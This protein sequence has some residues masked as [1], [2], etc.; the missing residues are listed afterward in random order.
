MHIC[1]SDIS[2]LGYTGQWD[3]NP[4]L[5]A[6]P[7]GILNL[8]D[9]KF[10]DGKPGDNIRTVI[11]IK[12]EG[13]NA[14]APLWEKTLLE[15]F[16]GNQEIVDYVQRVFGY[17]LS[18]LTKY[19][20]LWVLEG[21]KG[22]NGKSLIFKILKHVL[23]ELIGIL[24]RELLLDKKHPRQSGS[25]APDILTLRGKRMAFLMETGEGRK[26]DAGKLKLLSG[27]D[28]LHGRGLYSRDYSIFEN[29][30]KL[31]VLTNSRPHISGSDYAAWQRIILLP[32]N[33]SFVPDPNPDPKKNERLANPDLEE[34]LKSE[35]PGILAWLAKGYEKASDQGLTP[36]DCIKEA[37]SEYR[38]EED[39]IGRFV[40]EKIRKNIGGRL[41]A[42]EV[43]KAYRQWCEGEGLSPKYS[44]TF[45]REMSIHVEVSRKGHRVFY[46]DIKIR[47]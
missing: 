20:H 25:A 34:A 28:P 13:I 35:A 36:P 1:R 3:T 22:R 47:E 44:T 9:M 10:R 8:Q 37:T 46:M 12:W 4:Y 24:D 33:I 23:G 32:F 26:F 18:G 16:D 21:K 41:R 5:V 7:N 6:T 42:G 15:I 43:Y 39:T 27:G 19:H 11:P 30:A 2:Y 29:M 45:G 38:V 31:F 14:H 17:C 40:A